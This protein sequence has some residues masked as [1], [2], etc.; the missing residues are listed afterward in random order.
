[1]PRPKVKRCLRF[2]PNVYYFKPRGVPLRQLAEMVLLAEEVEAI[3][4]HEV[5]GL[6]Q[7]AAAR[8][9]KISQ[10]TFGRILNRA[11]QKVGQALI[12]GKAIKIEMKEAYK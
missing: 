5:D 1:M 10:P 4:L 11:Y 7:V 6:E 9:M 8:R 12:L 3:K 2:K